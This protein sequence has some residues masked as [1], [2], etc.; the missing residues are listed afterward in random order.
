MG[1]G[2]SD[3][4]MYCVL[5]LRLVSRWANAGSGCDSRGFLHVHK[6]VRS[7]AD[8]T[9]ANSST[10]PL[11]HALKEHVTEGGLARSLKH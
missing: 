5:G 11:S 1:L 3:Q 10:A 8:I 9:A 7:E 2:Y 6:A 4:N